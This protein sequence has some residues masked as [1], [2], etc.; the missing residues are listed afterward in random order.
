MKV[1]DLAE[2]LIGLYGDGGENEA[3]CKEQWE[4]ILKLD[5]EKPFSLVNFF[6]FRD[7]AK[8]HEKNE[9]VGNV[10]GEDAFSQ[11][12]QISIPTME[13][14][15]GSFLMVSPCRGSFLGD[16]EDWDLIA[17]GNYPNQ[18]AFLGLFRDE[19]YQKNFY[20]R[21]AACEKQ[22]VFIAAA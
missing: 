12:A 17:I 21:T 13:R 6:K 9:G 1:N 22:K 14:V 3:P 19:K 7:I 11:Y 15:G 5:P 18:K 10:S 4:K 2:E 8:Y 16:E 20:H